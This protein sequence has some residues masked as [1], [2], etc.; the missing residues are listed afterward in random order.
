MDDPKAEA[1]RRIKAM[2]RESMGARLKAAKSKPV[3]SVDVSVPQGD[4]EPPLDEDELL[5]GYESESAEG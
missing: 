3:L 2:A 4:P 5:R 1:L